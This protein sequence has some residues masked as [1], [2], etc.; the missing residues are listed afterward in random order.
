MESKLNL[1]VKVSMCHYAM[2]STMSL[3]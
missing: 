1:F 3:S 2:F